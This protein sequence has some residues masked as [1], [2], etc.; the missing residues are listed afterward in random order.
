[1]SKMFDA[2]FSCNSQV[3]GIAFTGPGDLPCRR[4]VH[5]VGP[6]WAVKG[7][8][9]SRELLR[10]AC[11][12]SLYKV[13]DFKLT[14]I[15]FPAISSGI[16]GM[17]KDIS[18]EIMF[19]AVEEYARSK[20]TSKPI[21]TDVRFVIIDDLTVRVFRQEFKFRYEGIDNNTAEQ[22]EAKD[23][24]SLR[25]PSTIKARRHSREL[26]NPPRNPNSPVN[27]GN[28]PYQ[29]AA[30]E[31]TGDKVS[32]SPEMRSARGRTS[33]DK[34]FTHV[35]V[36]DHSSGDKNGSNKQ[37]SY[38]GAVTG[39]SSSSASIKDQYPQGKTPKGRGN[40]G[41]SFRFSE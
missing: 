14:S 16:Y 25:D 29:D 23:G 38:S 4:I 34:A 18:A 22:E 8:V 35:K 33:Q 24:K 15:A 11:L 9:R 19:G 1:M 26:Y 31:R 17:P 13:E 41:T 6:V 40:H 27:P 7:A 21:V 32:G 20:A 12:N 30:V 3:G 36:L 39:K 28:K 5:A 2:P 10:E 37:L